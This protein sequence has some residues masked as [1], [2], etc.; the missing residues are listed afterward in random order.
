MGMAS[1][2]RGSFLIRENSCSFVV[3]I[4]MR[5]REKKRFR[6]EEKKEA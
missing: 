1:I 5:H 3:K 6:R 2:V 4:G